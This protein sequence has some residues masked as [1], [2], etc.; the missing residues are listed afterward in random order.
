MRSMIGR[1][2]EG[3]RQ[4]GSS[5][6]MNTSKFKVSMVKGTKN[7][8]GVKNKTRL[9]GR[10]GLHLAHGAKK[11]VAEAAFQWIIAPLENRRGTQR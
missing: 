10:L 2:P 8:W 11:S 4:I 7:P 5:E 1:Q 3:Q 9:K 6:Y